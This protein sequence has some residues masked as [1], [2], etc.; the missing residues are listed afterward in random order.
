MLIRKKLSDLKPDHIYYFN[1][2]DII[3]RFREF[4]DSSEIYP[5]VYVSPL[6]L[7]LDHRVHLP[8]YMGLFTL[9]VKGYDH[10][11]KLDRLELLFRFLACEKYGRIVKK[12]ETFIVLN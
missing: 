11:Y 6:V 8:N 4:R 12:S 7:F 10:F 1:D 5:E 2:A 9:T 3:V